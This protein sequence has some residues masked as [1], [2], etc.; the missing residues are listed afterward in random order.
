MRCTLYCCV[1]G[2][3]DSVHIHQFVLKPC[4]KATHKIVSR[5]CRLVVKRI[6]FTRCILFIGHI[7]PSW[8]VASF[9]KCIH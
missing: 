8:H 9:I 5:Y 2:H 4:L 3:A 1:T 6:S 7:L